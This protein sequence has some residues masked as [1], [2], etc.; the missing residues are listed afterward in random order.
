MRLP[1]TL[2]LLAA[3]AAAQSLL[4][5]D[6]LFRVTAAFDASDGALQSPAFVDFD[7]ASVFVNRAIEVLPV[8]SELWVSDDV[9]HRITRWSRFGGAQ[10]GVIDPG[11][12]RLGGMALGFGSIWVT[13]HD[14]AAGNFLVELDAGG[15]L[16]AAHP[17][18][19]V[20]EDVIVYGAELLVS[21]STDEVLR[22]DPATGA[23]S[24]V[25]HA[26]NGLDDVDGPVQ[27]SVRA[28]GNVLVAGV[29]HPVGI[30]E[31]DPSGATVAHY[32][33]SGLPGGGGVVGV[34]ELANGDLLFSSAGGVYVFDVGSGTSTQVLDGLSG[35]HVSL[36]PDVTVG[37]NYCGPAVPNSAGTRGVMAMTG[38]DEV[39]VNELRLAAHGLPQQRFGYFLASQTQGFVSGPGGSQ[40][41]LCL[42][43]NIG[44]YTSLV[45]NTGGSTFLHIPVDLTAVPQGTG[46][47]VAQPGET[48]SFS[49]WYRDVNP[50]ST[51][52]FA[53]GVAVLLR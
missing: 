25:F 29:L 45:A 7:E 8:G 30:F 40:G 23:V 33:T 5:P 15:G 42:G 21:V 53:D 26:S 11:F 52:N 12:K 34:Q 28:N 24:G 16:I 36:V 1:L 32:D 39:A 41:N 46:P 48:W 44:R 6:N 22:V 47:V 37:A 43:G 13:S 38:T 2:A 50:H 10:L 51:S 20:P 4:V 49:C 14:G 19:A 18:P 3:P 17:L 9:L 35:R 31:Y 27:L